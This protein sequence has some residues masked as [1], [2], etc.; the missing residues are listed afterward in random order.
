MGNQGGKGGESDMIPQKYKTTIE[1]VTAEGVLMDIQWRKP[2]SS[3]IAE[4]A[5]RYKEA[6]PRVEGHVWY[7]ELDRCNHYNSTLT[8]HYTA[9]L[10]TYE[11]DKARRMKF[12]SPI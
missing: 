6:L 8:L 11:D 3:M 9:V 5:Q 10:T 12:E 1:R 4:A 2:V 7:C